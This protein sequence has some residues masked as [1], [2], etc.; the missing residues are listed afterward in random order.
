MTLSGETSS[1]L[2]LTDFTAGDFG[3]YTCTAMNSAGTGSGSITVE[4]GREF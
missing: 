3:N 4:E 2:A 1:T